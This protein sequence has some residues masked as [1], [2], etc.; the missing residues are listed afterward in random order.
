MAVHQ[1]IST[2]RPIVGDHNPT[3]LLELL[4]EGPLEVIVLGGGV[5]GLTCALELQKA[6]FKVTIWAKTLSPFT[7]SDV[8]AA[9]WY[10]FHVLPIS[11]V[12]V[13]GEH[14]FKV[15]VD[16]TGTPKSGVFMAPATI[17]FE[18]ETADPLWAAYVPGFERPAAEDLPE[19]Y[20]TAYRFSTPVIEMPVYLAYLA[21][22]FV[23]GG[24]AIVKRETASLQEALV[25][26]K[27]VVNSTGL[28]S[29][30]LAN[31][32][33]MFPIRGQ[34]VR[35]ARPVGEPYVLLVEGTRS[36]LVYIVYRSQDAII[37]GTVE[38][39][40]WR[41]EPDPT[42]TGPML[43]AATTLAPEIAGLEVLDVLVGLRPG[44]DEVR[45]E[46]EFFAGFGYVTHCYGH[47]GGGVSLSWGC[48][49][50]VVKLVVSS[51]Q[52]LRIASGA[53]L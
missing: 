22:R 10:P 11:K 1:L 6:G 12:A 48:A 45:I 51:A 23:E 4:D 13:W 49:Q 41:L 33:R 8:A 39:G 53:G 15:L 28:S 21:D 3:N 27:L 32:E 34:V 52:R 40:N 30:S 47:G 24:G 29:R 20:F 18:E 16:L 2:Q 26:S 7:T 43:E 37:G 35:V 38:E 42:Q 19:G 17:L 50:E 31:D 36:G 14:T 44:R 9:F 5:I 46:S 25:E